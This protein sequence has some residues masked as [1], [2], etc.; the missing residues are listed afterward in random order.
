[1]HVIDFAGEFPLSL[2]LPLYLV[3]PK[4]SRFCITFDI[5]NVY[6]VA[7]PMVM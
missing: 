2:Y 4:S 6:R 3:F 1:M 7:V 5:P